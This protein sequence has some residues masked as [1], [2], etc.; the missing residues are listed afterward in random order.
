MQRCKDEMVKT[1]RLLRCQVLGADIQQG[2]CAGCIV[3]AKVQR[4][5]GAEEMQR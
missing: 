2:D 3:E 5:R 1:R 4:C